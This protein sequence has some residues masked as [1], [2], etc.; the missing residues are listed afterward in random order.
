MR[1]P[2]STATAITGWSFRPPNPG[3]QNW[4]AT[5]NWHAGGMLVRWRSLPFAPRTMEGIIDSQ[6]VKLSRLMDELPGG[7]RRFSA[8]DRRCQI[9]EREQGFARRIACCARETIRE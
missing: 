4:G 2:R 9:E 3:I 7:T 8:E 5:E 6:L 1:R